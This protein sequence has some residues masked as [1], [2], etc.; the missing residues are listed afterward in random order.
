MKTLLLIAVIVLGC[1][2]QTA[3][4]PSDVY[5]KVETLRNEV[6]LLKTHA[7]VTQKARTLQIHSALMPRDAFQ[8]T[9]TIFVKINVYRDMN[10]LRAIP[11]ASMNPVLKM[12]P[13]MTYEQVLRLIEEVRILK[14]RMGITATAPAPKQA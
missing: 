5:T 14:M 8:I 12:D 13:V 1:H 11:I 2:G 7:G 4:T 9:Y 3:I 10:G 6:Q